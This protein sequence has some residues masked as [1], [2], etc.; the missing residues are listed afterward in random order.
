MEFHGENFLKKNPSNVYE[1]FIEV[2]EIPWNSMKFSMGLHG[3]FYEIEIPW[4][5]MKFHEMENSTGLGLPQ[6]VIS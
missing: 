1:K 6:F 5:S 4:N 2:H 3:I